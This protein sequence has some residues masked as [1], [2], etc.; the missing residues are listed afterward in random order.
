MNK[1][2]FTLFASRILILIVI[3]LNLNDQDHEKMPPSVFFYHTEE[4]EV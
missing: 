3:Y 1:A 2:V 4:V